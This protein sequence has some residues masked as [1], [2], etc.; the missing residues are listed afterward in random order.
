LAKVDTDAQSQ[1]VQ[2][3]L[4]GLAVKKKQELVEKNDRLRMQFLSAQKVPA[5]KAREPQLN[6]FLAQVIANEKIRELIF[7]AW[8]KEKTQ[9]IGEIPVLPECFRRDYDGK[10][11][12][13]EEMETAVKDAV[14]TLKTW[15]KSVDF[16]QLNIYARLGPF[17]LPAKVL[18][19]IKKP[20]AKGTTANLAVAEET[21][22]VSAP[23]PAEFEAQIAQLQSQLGQ[24][25]AQYEARLA[26]QDDEL[27]KFKRLLEE[28]KDKRKQE[29]LETQE[30]SR[31]ESVL[32]QAE[33]QRL[34]LQLRR[35]LQEG[36][37]ARQEQAE[38]TT[39]VRDELLPIKQQLEKAEKEVKRLT[40]HQQDARETVARLE[41]ESARLQAR[42]KGLE[43]AQ[44]QL[45]IKEK[46]LA[47]F[48][49]QGASVMLTASDN[50]R[51]W[52]ESLNEQEVKEAFSRTFNLD[53]IKVSHYEHDERDLHETW[54]ML[55]DNERE[56][57]ERF[58]ALPFNELQQPSEEF[59]DVIT[60][61]IELKDSLVAREQLAHLINFVGNRFLQSQR[62]KV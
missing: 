61:F 24:Q 45:V 17:D 44:Q 48:E 20:R 62:Q 40:H 14:A 35:E 4:V 18:V 1:A 46:Q 51:I 28:S 55:I 58:F 33:W 60:S 22:E 52:E 11:V 23:L 39:K 7:S 53:N 6:A 32:R 41:E 2:A 10:A 42:I 37:R 5:S 54:K 21:K 36:Q 29:L 43:S 30:K 8:L 59:K 15:S 26:K 27:T 56:L 25:Q 34:E 50:L 9:D 12:S 49:R 13:D 38:K 31:H 47:R 19:A 16:D 57:T 3:L